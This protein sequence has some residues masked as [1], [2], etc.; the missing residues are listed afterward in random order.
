MAPLHLNKPHEAL[1]IQAGE[2]CPRSLGKDHHGH[3]GYVNAPKL[4]CGTSL[5]TNIA[6]GTGG[7]GKELLIHL[8]RHSPG[9]LFFTGR[10]E[11]AA[12]K[13]ITE[14]LTLNPSLVVSFIQC[15]LASVASI[16]AAA[17]KFLDN[18]SRLDI[19]VANAGIMAVPSGQTTDGHEI[20]FG[21]N[22]VGHAA[23][24][25]L[26]LP[27]MLRTAAEP[28]AEVRLLMATSQG[29][30]LHPT[31]GIK[32][33]T[34]HTDQENMNTW[35]KYGQAKV[36]AIL[37]AREIASRYPQ[38][39]CVSVHP[40]IIRTALISNLRTW[41]KV[42][43]YVTSVGRLL[44]PYQGAYNLTWCATTKRE[45]LEG[46]CY[47]KPVGNKTK[48]A[49]DGANPELGKKLWEW[50]EKEMIQLGVKEF[51]SGYAQFW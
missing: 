8:A 3:W 43:V 14:L 19:L 48:V 26:L 39:L 6:A 2:R 38:I 36:A 51:S 49:R 31:G 27:T 5:L 12:A 46:G 4:P 20:Q 10:N 44:D 9:P 18:S 15:D 35:V 7:I 17:K 24:I 34:L 25:K 11:S 40:G 23:L 21:T 45:N 29:Y 33:D 47:Y 41:S 22:F 28:G 1:R 16:K 13:V 50:T 42:F 37:W 32:F 30:G